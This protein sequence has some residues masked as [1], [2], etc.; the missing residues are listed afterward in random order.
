VLYNA[1]VVSSQEV[2][3]V[4]NDTEVAIEERRSGKIILRRYQLISK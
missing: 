3:L 4:D 2:D 1:S